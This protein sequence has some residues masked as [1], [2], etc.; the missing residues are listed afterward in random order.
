MGLFDGVSKWLAG[1]RAENGLL[2]PGRPEGRA[3]DLLLTAEN[4]RLVAPDGLGATLSW[5]TLL[6]V[7]R[8]REVTTG[9]TKSSGD[10]WYFGPWMVDDEGQ[11]SG[12]AVLVSGSCADATD[13]LRQSLTTLW[14]R[15]S[16]ILSSGTAVPLYTPNFER[17]WNDHVSMLAVLCGVLRGREEWRARLGDPQRVQRLASDMSAR[18]YKPKRTSHGL[19]QRTWEMAQAMQTL[20][21]THEWDGRPL[22]TEQLADLEEIVPAVLEKIRASPYARGLDV[23][24]DDVRAFANKY[25]F[26]DP[27]PFAALA[28]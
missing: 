10:V 25:Y 8:P 19:R 20:G 2:I 21:Y 13:E 14:T 6:Y 28:D 22:P 1:A 7:P 17:A 12:A 18:R 5:S 26:V 3:C 24:E 4:V 23:N 16:R 27:W 9:T 11:E 15:F